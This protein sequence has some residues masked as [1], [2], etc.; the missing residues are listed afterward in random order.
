M[1]PDR[2]ITLRDPD[3]TIT[4][5]GDSRD[6]LPADTIDAVHA[7]DA[8]A[9]IAER[10]DDHLDDLDGETYDRDTAERRR[11]PRRPRPTMPNGGLPRHHRDDDTSP[12]PPRTMSPKCTEVEVGGEIVRDRM[13]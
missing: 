6:R 10:C 4:F 13:N 8:G 3:G 9:A 7:I 11:R 1:T 12:L 2:I 5:D